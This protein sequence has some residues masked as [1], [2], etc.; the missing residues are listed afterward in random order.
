MVI[1]GIIATSAVLIFSDSIVRFL[2]GTDE[3]F[4]YTK[5]YLTTVILFSVCFMCGY[6][7][8]VYIRIDGNPTF[9]MISVISGGILNVILDYLFIAVLK[10]GI[11]G[12]AIATGLAQISMS[13]IL[14]TYILKKS[15]KLKFV[16]IDNFFRRV[17]KI[18]SMGISEFLAEVSTGISIYFFNIAILKEIGD[19]GVTAFGIISYITTFV[20]M[21]MIG[22]N[23]GLQPIVSL[24]L[25]RKDYKKIKKVFKIAITTVIIS[26]LIFYLVINIFTIDII[27]AFINEK[28]AINLTKRSMKIYSL[29]YLLSGINILIAGYFTS[30]NK[31]KQAS[32]ITALRGIILIIILIY[33][34]PIVFGELGL[35]LTVPIAE[36]ITLIISLI[37]LKRFK[38]GEENNEKNKCY[39]RIREI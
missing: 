7:M 38:V 16:K 15:K 3:L 5:E 11:R 33:V 35:W 30:I 14:L 10:M 19:I 9:P 24:N 26:S 18:I 17:F 31:A 23:Q 25:G 22:F 6:A 28:V 27:K 20:T 34:L 1:F 37:F 13:I 8:E 36:T 32:I 39:E 4:L 12:A 21:A 2:G 29:S